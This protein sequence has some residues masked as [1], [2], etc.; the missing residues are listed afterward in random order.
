MLI[1]GETGASI[2]S[3]YCAGCGMTP[4]IGIRYVCSVCPNYDL[5][6]RCEGNNLHRHHSFFELLPSMSKPAAGPIAVNGGN[7]LSSSSSL[8]RTPSHTMLR[9]MLPPGAQASVTSSLNNG[10]PPGLY[11]PGLA[12]SSTSSG[13]N[14]NRARPP[15]SSPTGG[16]SGAPSS[17][18]TTSRERSP[19]ASGG[20]SRSGSNAS[21]NGGG[22]S[23]RQHSTTPHKYKAKFVRD[24]TIADRSHVLPAQTMV[25]TW[26]VSNVGHSQWPDG[27]KLVFLRGDRAI[28]AEEEYPVP[29][30][31]VG[32]T[33]SVSV[34][35]ATPALSGRYTAF[36][37]LAD[38][39]R[40]MFGPRLWVDV[41]VDSNITEQQEDHEHFGSQVLARDTRNA[42]AISVA[43]SVATKSGVEL[44]DLGS[45]SST[46]H[47]N[48]NGMGSLSSFSALSIPSPAAA[49]GSSTYGSA[50]YA[51]LGGTV[52]SSSPAVANSA[53]STV[54]PFMSASPSS[55][56]GNGS[57]TPSSYPSFAFTSPLASPPSYSL[58]PS[59][60]HNGNGNNGMNNNGN[61]TSLSSL[62]MSSSLSSSSPAF[63]STL[64]SL[65]S[66]SSGSM[67]PSLGNGSNGGNGNGNGNVARSSPSLSISSSTAS[68]NRPLP[69]PI[70]VPP[71]GSHTPSSSSLF[72]PFASHTQPHT[73]GDRYASQLKSL[74]GNVDIIH[75]FACLPSYD[76][77]S[78]V[79]YSMNR[80]GLCGSKPKYSI[81]TASKW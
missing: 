78:N 12:P 72:T 16:S 67:Y 62:A 81:A 47:G 29:R 50:A 74:A 57:V 76:S 6:S 48:G 70:G 23:W 31:L 63:V 46:P 58:Y 56:N 15:G 22:S 11:P 24:V 69:S 34:V 7:A 2:D 17:T 5:C 39:K 45:P 51:G 68:I 8:S 4:I 53:S 52:R 13:G 42:H 1:V 41:L 49:G 65:S 66:G 44:T 21:N 64:S 14:N 73:L 40:H 55:S 20:R 79:C 36:F 35:I 26:E 33:V 60:G 10:P 27:V 32:Q 80:Y 25:K 28:S 77:S 18:S 3:S 75:L 9:S 59:G 61:G 37:R 30:A 54:Y 19:S 71:R 38:G 43:T